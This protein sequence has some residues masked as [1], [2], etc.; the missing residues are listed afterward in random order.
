M[1]TRVG[2]QPL[3]TEMSEA[4][5]ESPGL[6]E[7]SHEGASQ[8]ESCHILK[9]NDDVLGV[10]ACKLCDALRPLLVVHLS[11]AAKGLRAAMRVLPA[12]ES[13][14]RA[15]QAAVPLAPPLLVWEPR[16]S[17]RPFRRSVP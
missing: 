4:S 7:P 1:S 17:V 9:L 16:A 10:L 12:W 5:H 3:N 11:S 8:D 13:P 15:L 14:A 6:D 2:I